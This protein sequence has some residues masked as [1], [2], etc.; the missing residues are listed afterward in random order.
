V[1]NGGIGVL[2]EYAGPLTSRR[3]ARLGLVREC[4]SGYAGERTERI[5]MMATIPSR[6]NTIP[7]MEVTW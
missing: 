5:G 2:Y 7:A 6:T 3:E 1:R 4:G